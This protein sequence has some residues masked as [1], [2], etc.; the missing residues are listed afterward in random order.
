MAQGRFGWESLVR[1]E[2][3]VE[4]GGQGKNLKSKCREGFGEFFKKAGLANQMPRIK[5]CGSRN[6]ALDDFREAARRA[7]D[8]RIPILLVD[9]EGTVQRNNRPWQYLRSRDGWERPDGVTD[10][11]A[12]LM[13]QSMESWFL[14]D[15]SAL[16]SYFGPGF[17]SAAIPQR[18]DIELVPKDDVFEQLESA[19][20]GSKKRTYSKGRHSFDILARI[21]PEKVVR[22]SHFAKRLIVT[23][24][25]Y[26]IPA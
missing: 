1:V 22:R 20:R 18:N 2:I 16:E 24:K 12:Q 3:Y 15:V 13:V 25:S 8:D 17:R 6:N 5:A 21:D 26:L 14:A 10:S 19:S 11:Q 7:R 9:S 23:L 4:G